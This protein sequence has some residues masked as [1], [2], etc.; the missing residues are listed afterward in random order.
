M[1]GL[2]GFFCEWQTFDGGWPSMFYVGGGIC[3]LFCVLWTFTIYDS[4][5]SH[6]RIRESE[7]RYIEK[8]MEGKQEGRVSM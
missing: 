8:A 2:G 7:R 1:L 3:L 4:P 6:P 5:A